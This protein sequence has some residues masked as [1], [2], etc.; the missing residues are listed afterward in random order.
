MA[1]ENPV[2]ASV[3]EA[4]EAEDEP[5][6]VG[7][8][9]AYLTAFRQVVKGRKKAAV[10]TH[11]APDP[12]AM[13]AMM[14]V[15]WLLA[16][17]CNIET[18]LFF[19]GEISHPQN[20]TMVNLLDP[21]LKPVADYTPGEHDLHIL[22][23][24][25]PSYAATGEHKVEFD[26]VI[27]HHAE[28]N[29]FKALYINL[30]AG[31]AASTVYHLIDQLGY[32][33]DRTIDNDARV[34]TAIIVGVYTDTEN[35]LSED[36]TNY[37]QEAFGGTLEARDVESLKAI[38]HY[39]RP[40]LWVKWEAEATIKL[41]NADQAYLDDGVAIVGLGVIPEKHRDVIADLAQKLV[42][43]E[44]IHTGVVFAIVGNDTIQGSVRSNNASL[45]VPDVCKKLGGKYGSGGGKRGKGAY[46][47]SLAG[48]GIDEGEDE[49]T[50]E[51][52]WR[53]FQKKEAQR[54]KRILAK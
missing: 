40:K 46:T 6:F 52:T 7:D 5:S 49:S 45:I 2:V 20:N 42:T 39:K 32:S 14:A 10:F 35:M 13:G 12:D 16:K 50:R 21:G 22:V 4:V 15:R 18:D 25:V 44:D 33:F 8:E 1:K 27:D 23:D 19:G 53:L 34:A 54:I 31:S 38:V 9:P 30:K 37:E 29:G 28:T 41:A 36:S 51:E 3:T 26:V 17:H 11:P 24:T 47:Y 43:W 48:G